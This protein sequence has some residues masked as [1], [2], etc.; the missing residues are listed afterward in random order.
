MRIAVGTIWPR[1]DVHHTPATEENLNEFT[2]FLESGGIQ[3]SWLR[4]HVHGRDLMLLSWYDTFDH[5]IYVAGS[6]DESAVAEFCQ[7]TNCEYTQVE[8]AS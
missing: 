2:A 8:R 5:P 4:V 1:P 3:Y 6:V 7:H